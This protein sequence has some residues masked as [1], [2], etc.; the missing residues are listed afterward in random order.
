MG[1]YK[2]ASSLS[3]NWSTRLNQLM[4]TSL[5]SPPN[6]QKCDQQL[7]LCLQK[8]LIHC[9]NLYESFMLTKIIR[10]LNL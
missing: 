4:V 8:Y 1:S 10:E 2:L 5:P 3:G 7:D 9:I 6:L